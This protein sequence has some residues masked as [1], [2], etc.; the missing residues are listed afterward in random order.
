MKS[1]VREACLA[2]NQEAQINSPSKVTQKTG[3]G[4]GEGL[5]VGMD[6]ER[7][8]IE[9]AAQRMA[10]AAMSGTYDNG[11][12]TSTYGSVYSNAYTTN[13]GG[14]TLNVSGAGVA[15]VDQLSDRVAAKLT[16]QVRIAQ[17]AR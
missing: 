8:E 14:I 5:V 10:D 17:R 11:W 3:A 1:M 6:K 2:A 16:Q 12:T 4:L 15:N 9:K 7:S 13:F